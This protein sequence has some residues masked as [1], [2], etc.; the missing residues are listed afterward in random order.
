MVEVME[1]CKKKTLLSH[2]LQVKKIYVAIL[3]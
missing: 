1:I 2:P 3:Q